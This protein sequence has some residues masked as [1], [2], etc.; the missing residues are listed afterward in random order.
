MTSPHNQPTV[1]QPQPPQNPYPP[2][3]YPAPMPAPQPTRPN[4]ISRGY[5]VA[6]IIIAIIATVAALMPLWDDVSVFGVVGLALTIIAACSM[7]TDK[8]RTPVWI[9]TIIVAG[10]LCVG[11]IIVVA[12]T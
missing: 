6:G 11:S 12:L 4:D 1:P 5:S 2:Y 3:P 8:G 7:L 10:I 9:G